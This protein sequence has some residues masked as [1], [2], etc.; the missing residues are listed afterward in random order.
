MTD[1]CSSLALRLCDLGFDHCQGESKRTVHF[2][3]DS[4]TSLLEGP[5]VDGRQNGRLNPVEWEECDE[6]DSSVFLDLCLGHFYS[7]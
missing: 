2:G 7:R 5:K 1:I 6:G 3:L 4:C